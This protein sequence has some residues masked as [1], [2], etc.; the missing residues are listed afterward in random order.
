MKKGIS[1][2][3]S[4]VILIA[5]SIT[6]GVVVATWVTHLIEEQ[7]TSDKLCAINTLYNIESAR[8]NISGGNQLW[9]KVTNDG[10]EELYGFGVMM[11]NGTYILT[12]NS[13]SA[14]LNQG[15][16]SST[17]ELKRKQSAYLIVNLTN[18]TSDNV[19]YQA[20]GL[21]LTTSNGAEITVTN[22]A[23]TSISTEPITSITVG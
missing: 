23:C 7:T 17:N 5:V 8:F 20:F 19:N 13:T 6:V 4:T 1:P 10:D 16:I 9:L 15:N 14:R 11:D 18:T 21:S 22:E 2:I 12:M 3:I